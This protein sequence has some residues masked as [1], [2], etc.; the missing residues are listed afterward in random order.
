MLTSQRL[1]AAALL[2]ATI[3]AVLA[4]LDKVGALP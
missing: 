3:I 2:A 1:V 4:I